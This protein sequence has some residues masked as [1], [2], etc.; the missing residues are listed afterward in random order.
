LT[1]SG[2][3]KF[4]TYFADRP[5]RSAGKATHDRFFQVWS[6]GAN[7]FASDPPNAGLTFIQD[8]EV[9]CAIIELRN[10]SFTDGKITYAIKV[11]DGT[12]PAKM[13]QVSMFID[14]GGLMCLVCNCC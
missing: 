2:V 10:P 6:Q 5:A 14:P 1:L 13:K 12:V 4:T 11:L 9:G 7:S 8:G 3:G